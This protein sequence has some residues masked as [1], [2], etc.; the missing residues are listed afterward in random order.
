VG[1]TTDM[2][3]HEDYADPC[4]PKNWR[5][6]RQI[7]IG[8]LFIAI[9]TVIVELATIPHRYTKEEADRIAVGM[10]TIE[11]ETIMGRP[12]DERTSDASISVWKSNTTS[13]D[14]VYQ[15]G[16]VTRAVLK[17]S[18]QAGFWTRWKRHFGIWS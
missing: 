2:S 11:V 9:T 16:R 14:V 6:I 4:V 18:P 5:R 7:I 13:I 12:P 15:D 3:A 1:N 8:L 17:S 10:T